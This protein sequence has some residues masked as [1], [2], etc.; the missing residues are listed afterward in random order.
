MH[1][2]ALQEEYDDLKEALAI[3]K[4]VPIIKCIRNITGEGLKQ[5]KEIHDL[6]YD[7][8]TFSSLLEIFR[9]ATHSE[10]QR[11]L[12]NR[13]LSQFLSK[14]DYIADAVAGI[15]SDIHDIIFAEDVERMS[16]DT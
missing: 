5:S 10:R 2:V 8:I 12:R 9:V 6:Y 11:I 3:G 13:H 7:K 14:L 15:R 1:Y 4:K 16:K